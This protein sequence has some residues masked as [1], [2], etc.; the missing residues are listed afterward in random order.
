MAVCSIAIREGWLRFIPFS[1]ADIAICSIAVKEGRL[2]F[3]PFP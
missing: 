1:I 3:I 2:R